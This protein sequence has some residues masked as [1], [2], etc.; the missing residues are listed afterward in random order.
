MTRSIILKS[1]DDWGHLGHHPNLPEGVHTLMMHDYLF[2][3]FVREGFGKDDTRMM[4]YLTQQ[5]ADSAGKL[6]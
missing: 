1:Q 2:V 6:G 5:E 4:D 3:F